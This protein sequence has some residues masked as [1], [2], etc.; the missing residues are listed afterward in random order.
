MGAGLRGAVEQALSIRRAV[1]EQWRAALADV[2]SL[3]LP[4][5]D[6]AREPAFLRFPVL[7]DTPACR[8]RTV[9]TLAEAGFGFVRSFPEPLHRI[10]AF[11]PFL[12]APVD[13]PGA[14]AL[15]GRIVALPCHVGVAG[16]DIERAGRAMRGAQRDP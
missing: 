13:A 9:T 1:A 6:P 8:E 16:R 10:P 2:G 3:R 7:A 4:P 5:Q 11:A 12:A 15:A 14:T